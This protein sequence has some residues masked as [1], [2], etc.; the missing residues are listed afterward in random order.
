[1][2]GFPMRKLRK[3]GAVEQGSNVVIIPRL[4]A[5]ISRPPGTSGAQHKNA[6]GSRDPALVPP[7][8]RTAYVELSLANVA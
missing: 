6:Y 8:K 7:S 4:L 5:P 1:M 3:T 2:T